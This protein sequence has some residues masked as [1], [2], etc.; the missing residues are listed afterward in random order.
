MVSARELHPAPRAQILLA[1]DEH[2]HERCQRRN[3]HP[4]H[5]LKQSVIVEQANDEHP[6]QATGD[7]VHL[8]DVDSGEFGMQGGTANFD[9]AQRTDDQHERDQRPIEVAE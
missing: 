8:P 2:R 1:E 9:D 3:V 6:G 4:V 7:P 5:A